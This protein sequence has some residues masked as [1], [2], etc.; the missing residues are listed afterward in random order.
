[1]RKISPG[2]STFGEKP[3]QAAGKLD[4]PQFRLIVRFSEYLRPLMELAERHIPEEKR[5]YTPVFIFATAGMRLLPD[6][7]KEAVLANLRTK[8]PKITSMQ[9]LKEHIRIIEGKWEGI[10]SWI[11]VN[12]ALGTFSVESWTMIIISG[13]FNK[14]VTAE[15]AFPGTSPAQSRQKTVGMIDMGG[16]SAQIAFEMPDNDEFASINVE[17]VCAPLTDF[18]WATFTD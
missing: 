7:Q 16:A 4:I 11:A 14:T 5:A 12:Y 10:Y 2:L 18:C 9:V 6:E 17:N 1:M 8:L 3:E 15:V 13:K